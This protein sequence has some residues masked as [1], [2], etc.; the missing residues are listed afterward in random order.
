MQDLL[1]SSFSKRMQAYVTQSL[2]G[3]FVVQGAVEY[4]NSSSSYIAIATNYYSH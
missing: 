3:I 4:C 2:S 1:N